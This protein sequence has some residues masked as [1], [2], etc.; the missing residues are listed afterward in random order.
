MI[1]PIFM[2]VA[3]LLIAL[4]G[5][6]VG[7]SFAMHDSNLDVNTWIASDNSTQLNTIDL[8]SGPTASAAGSGG[9]AE[10]GDE[11]VEDETGDE[12]VEG[13]QQDEETDETDEAPED[14]NENDEE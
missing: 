12:V 9:A 7:T 6:Q 4:I 1:N 10:T 3:V 8:N 14:E 13:E 5:H 11:A 2:V